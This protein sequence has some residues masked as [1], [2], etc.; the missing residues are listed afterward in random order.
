ME[1]KRRHEKIKIQTE[2]KDLDMYN[3]ADSI[4]ISRLKTS[5]TN[6]EF[7][8][9]QITKLCEKIQEREGRLVL[10]KVRFNN[11]INWCIR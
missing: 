1:S 10:L 5:G 7:N 4:T 9:R 8:K 11:V 3:K 6:I 2:I